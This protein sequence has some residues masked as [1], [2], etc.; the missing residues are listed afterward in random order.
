MIS[1]DLGVAKPQPGIFYEACRRAHVRPASCVYVGDRF[2]TD[3]RAALNAGLAGIWIS[4]GG[5]P[6]TNIG[7]PVIASLSELRRILAP[8]NQALHSQPGIGEPELSNQE[9]HPSTD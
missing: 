7:V 6:I 3:A 1:N 9:A 8:H 4:R 5:R 2:E